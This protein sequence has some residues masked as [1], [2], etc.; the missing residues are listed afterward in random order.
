VHN[1]QSHRSY[2]SYLLRLRQVQKDEHLTWVASVQ[3]TASGEQ[4]SFSSV[5]ALVQFLQIEYGECEA[6]PEL[7]PLRKPNPVSSDHQPDP[8]KAPH[9]FWPEKEVVP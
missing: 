6:A 8:I 5:D 7:E 3:S 1:V 4:R 2:A 9:I